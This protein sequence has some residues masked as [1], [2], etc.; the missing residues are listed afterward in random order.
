MPKLQSHKNL[1]WLLLSIVI[2]IIDRIV[3]MF[4][5]QHLTMGVP[6]PITPF[7]NLTLV[8]NPGAAFSFLSN[9]SGWQRWFFTTIAIIISILLIIWLYRLPP[10]QCM[11]AI[12][13]SLIVGGAIGNIWG[14]ISYGY[15]IDFLDFHLNN[16]HWPV[17]TIADSA[18]C[19]GVVLLIIDMLGSNRHYR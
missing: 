3:K 13:I 8:H 12:A 6:L 19:V 1:S 5:Q 4:M 17:F 9:A 14:R 16:W 18:V 11:I 10:K 7:F 2:I 15:V